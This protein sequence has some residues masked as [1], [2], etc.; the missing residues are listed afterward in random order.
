[1][2][3]RYPFAQ[4]AV[5]VSGSAIELVQIPVS[6]V[7]LLSSVSY[8]ACT[9]IC[10]SYLFWKCFPFVSGKCCFQGTH[11]AVSIFEGGLTAD[12]RATGADKKDGSLKVASKILA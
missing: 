7:D 8:P 12:L 9:R 5:P 6:Q 10:N 11:T 4:A 2:I 3:S 1:M